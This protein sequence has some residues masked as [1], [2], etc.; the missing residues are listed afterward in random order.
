MSTRNEFN[1]ALQFLTR[2]PV[3]G[4]VEHS[5]E[6]F[7]R[8]SR[9]YPAVGLLVGAVAAGVYFVSSIFFPSILATVLALLT[10]VAVTGALHE[11]GLADTFDGLIGG[12]SRD[13]TLEIMR[14]SGI[15][16]YGILALIFAFALKLT[17][18]S[19][20]WGWD[21][22]WAIIVAHSISRHA[23]VEVIGRYDYAR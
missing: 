22:F 14:D 23:M 16:T 20:M 8:S 15:G 1:I 21:A 13:R 10:G 9:F 7:A 3:R 11:D 2:L 18:I 19:E 6:A 12:Q 5:D 17:A 4:D